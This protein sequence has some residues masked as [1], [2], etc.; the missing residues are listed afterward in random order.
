MNIH[1][2][3]ADEALHPDFSRIIEIK[4]N[5]GNGASL[6]EGMN[7]SIILE[8]EDDVA[9]ALWERGSTHAGY[10]DKISKLEKEFTDS[11]KNCSDEKIELLQTLKN[12]GLGRFKKNKNSYYFESDFHQLTIFK[13]YAE[14]NNCNIQ[15]PLFEKL[16]RHSRINFKK[17]EPIL[18]Q[19]E[20]DYKERR[21]IT[22]E[23]TETWLPDREILKMRS[24]LDK[25]PRGIQET[26]QSKIF[27]SSRGIMANG[28]S[29]NSF[30]AAS[31]EIA[32]NL[33]KMQYFPDILN[34]DE[35]YELAAQIHK[36]TA[37]SKITKNMLIIGECNDETGI[38][39]YYSNYSNTDDL[40][41][42]DDSYIYVGY[43][44]YFGKNTE[45]VLK[46]TC[47]YPFTLPKTGNITV[48]D[49]VL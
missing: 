40:T 33:F 5:V 44:S 24:F 42:L 47:N 14:H 20:K 9:A 31:K 26:L 13:D 4:T 7:S 36:F 21:F 15:R 41:M 10:K 1:K 25:L 46:L 27:G 39:A 28:Q 12:S 6:P 17:V 43:S 3:R 22:S 18:K 30:F 49:F 37:N 16:S 23:T 35:N 11:L 32:R 2:L 38:G 19:I 48:T 8:S 29:F 45:E 34:Y